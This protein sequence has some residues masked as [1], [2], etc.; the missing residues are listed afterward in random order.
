MWYL[1]LKLAYFGRVLLWLVAPVK[2]FTQKSLAVSIPP[3]VRWL[4]HI[5]VVLLVFFALHWV[6]QKLRDFDRFKDLIIPALEWLE[7]WYLPV[8]FLL[9]YTAC[10]LGW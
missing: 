4:L 6:N 1:W 3:A 8:L 7:N 10:W 5:A 2:T 9:W